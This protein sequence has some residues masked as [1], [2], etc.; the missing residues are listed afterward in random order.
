MAAQLGDRIDD[1]S[2]FQDE[3]RH[4]TTAGASFA[5]GRALR[6][7]VMNNSVTDMDGRTIALRPSAS[8]QVIPN[9]R[10]DVTR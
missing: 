9:V 5:P 2:G 7:R 4:S 6:E 10:R 8:F 3:T 1:G